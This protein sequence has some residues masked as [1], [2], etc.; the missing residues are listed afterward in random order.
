MEKEKDGGESRKK[1][2]TEAHGLEKWQVIKGLIDGEE[3]SVW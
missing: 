1:S 3:G 2:G